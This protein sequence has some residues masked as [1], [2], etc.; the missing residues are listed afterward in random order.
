MFNEPTGPQPPKILSAAAEIYGSLKTLNNHNIAL[1]VRFGGSDQ[2]YLSYIVAV[3]RDNA[4][5]A[6]DE[7]V[8]AE[9]AKFLLEGRRAHI[10]AMIDGVRLNWSHEQKAVSAK[11]GAHACYWLKFPQEVRYH[12][13]RGT[14]RA[15]LVVDQPASI[16]IN[17]PKLEQPLQGRLMD[18]SATG[19]KVRFEQLEDEINPGQ[20][21]DNCSLITP[22]GKLGISVEVRHIQQQEHQKSAFVGLRFHNMDGMAQRNIE[23]FVY[24]LQR[25]ARRND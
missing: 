18:I 25:E 5:L 21:F 24:Q 8:P 14:F 11:N 16:E 20:L 23:R 12:Q 17:L 3:D 19:C 13:R 10:E 7:L 6:F 22:V 1:K 2:Q 15:N 9:G 4:S